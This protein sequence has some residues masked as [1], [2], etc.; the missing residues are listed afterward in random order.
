MRIISKAE[1]PKSQQYHYFL[2]L[3]LSPFFFQGGDPVFG[4]FYFVNFFNWFSSGIPDLP[5]VRLIRTCSLSSLSLSPSRC[6]MAFHLVCN[7]VNFIE[8]VYYTQFHQNRKW[9][10][11]GPATLRHIGVV[12]DNCCYFIYLFFIWHN[13]SRLFLFKC[14]N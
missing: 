1:L 13:F 8:N 4:Q 7:H 12:E 3:S 9:I 10:R 11:K 5:P 14:K 2:S 6:Q